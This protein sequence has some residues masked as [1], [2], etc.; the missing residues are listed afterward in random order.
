MGLLLLSSI[1]GNVCHI[2]LVS[3]G[4]RRDIEER[5]LVARGTEDW[6]HGN[7]SRMRTHDEYIQL[8]RLIM[9]TVLSPITST[10]KTHHAEVVSCGYSS[11]PIQ[12]T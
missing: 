12:A 8:L 3:V 4:C 2:E 1:Q 7:Q 5:E 11:P 10:R 9:D 6:G